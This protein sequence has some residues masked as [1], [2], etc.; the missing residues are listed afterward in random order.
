MRSSRRLRYD[1]GM[2][3]L[4]VIALFAVA[5]VLN[6]CDWSHRLGEQLVPDTGSMSDRCVRIIRA[7]M[8]FADLDIGNQTSESPDV[9]TI[10]AKVEATRTDLAKD[11]PAE[12]DV[13][14]ECTFTD[15]ALT[16]FR[17]TKGGPPPPR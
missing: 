16:G 13:A 17:W 10:V 5:C 9:R 14:A 4:A 2:R 15:S 11:S 8:P 12:H 3:L 7:A 1:S 6:G